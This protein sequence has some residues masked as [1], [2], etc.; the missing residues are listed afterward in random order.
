MWNRNEAAK[1]LDIELLES[2]HNT[3]RIAVTVE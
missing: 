1:V 3:Q 2:L